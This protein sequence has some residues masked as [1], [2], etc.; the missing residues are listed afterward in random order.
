MSWKQKLV[1]KGEKFYR[2]VDKNSPKILTGV[3]IGGVIFAEIFTVKATVKAVRDVDKEKEEREKDAKAKADRAEK[4][5]GRDWQKTYDEEYQPL[6]KWDIFKISFPH[7]IP[8]TLMTT[9]VVA[10][11]IGAEK[12]NAGRQ[13]KLAAT[14]EAAQVALARYKDK[15]IETF[16]EKKERAVEHELHKEEVQK[17]MK[18]IPEE[19]LKRCGAEN[20]EACFY[21]PKTGQVF[22]STYEKVRRAA[23]KANDILRNESDY[24]AH[25]LFISDCGGKVSE[26]S[27]NNGILGQGP[28]RNAIDQ[29][30]FL[31]PHIEEYQGHEVTMVYMNYDT[32]TREQY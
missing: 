9:S 15:V 1:E 8:A 29:D 30:Y 6:T 19:Y 31:D 21:D 13:A 16:G 11:A 3:V 24:Y 28:Y 14:A 18:D 5:L 7:Y 32:V 2:L 4:L 26:F 12:I 25:A 23:E 17:H 22:V 10:S 20:G 27:Y